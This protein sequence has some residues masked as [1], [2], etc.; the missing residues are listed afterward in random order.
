MPGLGPQGPALL[1]L[2]ARGPIEVD[3]LGAPRAT[4]VDLVRALWATGLNGFWPWAQ[5]AV[6]G[7][8]EA[9]RRGVSELGPGPLA[10]VGQDR[11]VVEGGR[12]C[13]RGRGPGRVA[14]GAARFGGTRR[15]G[16]TSRFGGARRIGGTSRIGGTRRFGGTSRIGGA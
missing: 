3:W 5:L 11:R 1:A 15:I 2:G 13:R 10:A 7:W 16:G 6:A 12:A 8:R 14:V 9:G 4:E